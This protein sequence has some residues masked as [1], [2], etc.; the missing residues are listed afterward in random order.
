MYPREGGLIKIYWDL[1]CAGLCAEYLVW[2]C[3]I[4]KII[5]ILQRKNLRQKKVKVIGPIMLR[6]WRTERGLLPISLNFP[7]KQPDFPAGEKDGQYR[8]R[9]DVTE[10]G[11]TPALHGSCPSFLRFLANSLSYHL[12]PLQLRIRGLQVPRIG[13]WSPLFLGPALHPTPPLSPY[14]TPWWCWAFWIPLANWW[15]FLLVGH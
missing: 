12:F 7:T 8:R 2:S 9:S 15:A 10:R 14:H 13:P 5:S 4:S 11:P 6:L 1:E 3:L